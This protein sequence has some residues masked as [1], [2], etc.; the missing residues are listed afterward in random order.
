[1]V[2]GKDYFGAHDGMQYAGLHL[3][4][5]MWEAER[6]DDRIWIEAALNDAARLAKATVLHGYFHVF[7]PQC[8][9]SGVLLLAESHLSIHTWPERH[10]AAFDLFMCATCNPNDALPALEKAFRPGRMNVTEVRRG[11]MDDVSP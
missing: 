9:V 8:G 6:L 2:N 11:L 3:L 7:S 4:V 10:F 1:M 5:D